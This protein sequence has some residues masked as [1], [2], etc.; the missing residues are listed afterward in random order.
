MTDLT[1]ALHCEVLGIGAWG[2]GFCC[3]R[4]LSTLLLSTE[5]F[6]LTTS[7]PAPDIIPANERRRAPLLVKMAVET[8]QQAINQST[9]KP[10]QVACV[11]GSGIGDTDV[12]DYL[13]KT[14]LTEDK[15]LSPTRFHNSVHNTSAGYWTISTDCMQAAN[16]IAA[17]QHTAGMA[18]LESLC[19]T[20][21][22]QIPVLLTIYDMEVRMLF[23]EIFPSEHN[24]SVS[25]LI[26]PLSADHHTGLTITASIENNSAGLPPLRNPNLE[27]ARQN[28]PA[29]QL[30]NLLENIA[31]LQQQ[32]NEEVEPT[33]LSLS[34]TLSLRVLPVKEPSA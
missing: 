1:T 17:Y 23:T 21:Q 30:L 25:L 2:P 33:H 27:Q 16:S 29:A 15:L 20:Q 14:L 18:L 31:L 13:C 9:Y 8:S 6:D 11:F 12:T 7:K 10:T 5:A 3:W 22:Q 34:S 32:R 24:F 4:D 28:N 26:A 19:Q